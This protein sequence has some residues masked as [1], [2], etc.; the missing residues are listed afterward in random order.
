MNDPRIETS[1]ELSAQSRNACWELAKYLFTANT[2]AAAGMLFLLRSTPGNTLVLISFSLFCLGTFCVLVSIIFGVSYF[3][4]IAVGYQKDLAV[5]KNDAELGARHVQRFDGWRGKIAPFGGWLSFASLIVGGII[6]AVAL[7]KGAIPASEQKNP[8]LT[9]VVTNSPNI[10][11]VITSAAPVY[12]SG[13]ATNA[14]RPQI[15]SP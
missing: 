10:S 12:F 3:V 8:A 11:L 6:A 5:G 4:D 7:F 15:A 14:G 1:K 2:G 9:V 13:S